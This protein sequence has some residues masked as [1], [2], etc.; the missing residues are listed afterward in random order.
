M[1]Q[2]GSWGDSESD[3]DGTGGACGLLGGSSGGSGGGPARGPNGWIK[4]PQAYLLPNLKSPGIALGAPQRQFTG[5]APDARVSRGVHGGGTGTYE[6]VY[7]P[8]PVRS[9]RDKLQSMREE[10]NA[11]ET[12]YVR[13]RRSLE[14]NGLRRPQARDALGLLQESVAATR[15][16]ASSAAVRGVRVRGGGM[17]E[18]AE[19]GAASPDEVAREVGSAA[20]AFGGGAMQPSGGARTGGGGG[21]MA[22]RNA[23]VARIARE[24]GIG[25]GAASH[26]VKAEGLWHR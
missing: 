2:V 26:A 24:R 3:N 6:G 10:Q 7:L 25:I 13:R 5:V 8:A 22:S 16:G 12:A 4:N 21:G 11:L 20:G 9:T 17:W 14:I 1:G 23:I 15:A 18:D 19:D